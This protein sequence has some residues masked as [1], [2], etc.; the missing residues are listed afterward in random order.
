MAKL[1]SAST[2]LAG[3]MILSSA[4]IAGSP[5]GP[6][7]IGDRSGNP[8]QETYGC[9]IEPESVRPLAFISPARNIGP[10]TGDAE[11]DTFGYRALLGTQRD[12]LW[13]FWLER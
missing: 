3:I 11:R 4:A 8:E 5:I 10:V 6:T 7:Y 2:L 12:G 9:L 1:T 13:S